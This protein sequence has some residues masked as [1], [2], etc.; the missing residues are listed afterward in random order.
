MTE[1]VADFLLARL[2]DWGV[3]HVFAYPGDGINGIVGAFGAADNGLR[4]V[5]VR[6]EEMA[7]FAA[8][9]YAKFG[10]GVGVC[11][12]T[13]GPGAVHLLNGLYD[14]KLDHVPV[15]AIVGQT[16]RSAMGGSYQQEIDLQSLYKDVASDYLVEVNVAEQLPNA[17]D[18]AIRIAQA[19]RGPTAVIIPSDLQEEDFHAPGHEFKQVPSS[20]PGVDWPLVEPSDEAVRHA[21]EILNA[22]SKVAILI[23][24]GA[25]GAAAE[26]REVAEMTGAGVAKALLGKDVLPDDLPY[27]TGAIGLLGTRPSYELMRD[28]DTLLIVGSN[29]PYSQF[30]P[31]FGQAR[32]IQIDL[33]ASLIG[34]RYPTEVN[35][36][37]DAGAALGAIIPL[38]RHNE[39]TE[40]REEVT[41]NVARWW[42]TVERQAMLSADPVNPMRVVW[43]LSERLPDD[44]IVC[45]DSGSSTNWYARCL[46]MREGVRGSLS[47]TLATMG[48]GVPYA[49]GA[50]F[51]HPDRPVIALVGDGAMQMNGLAEL[52]TISRYYDKW[53]D[54][55]MV[56]CVFHNNDL[57]QVTW[58]LRAMGGYPKF[59]ESQTIPDISYA[60]IA[61]CMGLQA[62]AV[63][64][65]DELVA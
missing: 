30:L 17:L 6:H 35:I 13:S 47:G 21:A 45:A 20:D 52:L 36:V 1:T 29:F 2:R 65:P 10:G 8:T 63:D 43:E 56:I 25:R 48:P 3:R 61:R 50:K 23:G 46:K 58:E 26:V 34:M 40:W 24:Q 22:G 42:E 33:D 27:V 51:A 32:A 59:E 41:D 7:A 62:I 64:D 16:A 28:C 31:E 15:V 38:L 39:A 55:R 12:A 57:N 4:F 5:Q 19:R 37:A 18:R 44:A 53:L 9:G 54:P 60:D 49:I 14:A 11:M